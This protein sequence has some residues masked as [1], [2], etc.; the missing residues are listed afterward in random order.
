MLVRVTAGERLPWPAGC[1]K[2][3]FD[4][5]RFCWQQEPDKRP[6]FSELEGHLAAL[7]KGGEDRQPKFNS[8]SCDLASGDQHNYASLQQGQPGGMWLAA[9]SIPDKLSAVE[10]AFHS[11]SSYLQLAQPQ[12]VDQSSQ[13]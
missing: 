1:P 7:C 3:M 6:D 8:A 11:C 13:V 10:A 5:M 12:T 4:V 9:G 2:E